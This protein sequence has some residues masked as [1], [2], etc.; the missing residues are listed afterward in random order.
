MLKLSSRFVPVLVGFLSSILLS[1]CGGGETTTPSTTGNG[2]GTASQKSTVLVYMVGSD[3]ESGGGAGT[4]D[5]EE[6]MQIGSNDNLKVVVATGGANKDGWRTVKENLI[7]Q[8]SITELSDQ[9]NLNMGDPTTLQNFITRGMSN[10]PA[11]KYVLIL[12]DHGGGAIGNPTTGVTFGNDENHN[13]GLSLPEFKQALQNAYNTTGKKFDIIGFDACL[14]ATLETAHTVNP[15]AKYLVASE[16]LEPG[17]GWDYTNILSAIKSNPSIG[18]SALGQV[19]ADGYKA[20]ALAVGPQSEPTITL[21]VV[22]L[23]LI[24]NV[25][26]SLEALANAA[27]SDL[28][29][30]GQSARITIAKGRSNA[31]DYGSSEGKPSY[32]DMV[33][34]KHIASNLAITYPTQTNN[35]IAAVNSA[36]IY[37]VNGKARPNANGLSIFLPH[38]NINNPNLAPM[39]HAYN[40]INFSTA[41]QAFIGQYTGLGDQDDTAPTFSAE[42][43][44]GLV[45]SAQVQGNDIDTVSVVITQSDPA[46]GTVLILGIDSKEVDVAGNV[47]HE[48]DGEW[49]TMN[50]NYVSLNLDDEDDTVTTYTIPALLNGKGV[51]ILVMVENVTGNYL[52]MGG[53]TGIENGVA[54][55]EILPIKQGDVITPLFA[56]YNV[57][58]DDEEYLPGTAFTVGA[59]GV[60]LSMAPLPAGSYSLGF[61]AEDYAQNEEN[62]QFVMMNVP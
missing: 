50:G 9:G 40:N 15:Y 20:H 31:E 57:N 52:I 62:S 59:T 10:Y 33:D 30:N 16:E 22:D 24:P 19:I 23:S 1:S 8:G 37:K 14:M 12:W 45:Y 27:G 2:S 36:V 34:L 44:T 5:I 48:W 11:E 41:Y 17:H 60:Q 6:M 25:I 29:N 21:S 49:V 7:N 39:I 61:I 3:L 32:F 38:K 56:S 18:G 58:T 54:A 53:W 47:S 26:T 28:Q 4:T 51:D 46:T 42:T 55:K 35:L 43:L 13:D